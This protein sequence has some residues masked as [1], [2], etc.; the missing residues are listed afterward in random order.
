MVGLMYGSGLR[1]MECLSLRILDIDFG[2]YEIIVRAGKG[3][4]DRVTMLPE[5]VIEGL[6]SAIEK[7]EKYHIQNQKDNITHVLNKG[8]HGVKSPLD[9]L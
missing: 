1:L 9:N 8:G 3:N 2:R 6:K 7:V 4:K 5:F